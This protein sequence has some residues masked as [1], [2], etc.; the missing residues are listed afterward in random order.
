MTKPE[1][2]CWSRLVIFHGSR[3]LYAVLLLG[4]PVLVS[5]QEATDPSA[6]RGTNAS[7]VA[8]PFSRYLSPYE[9][10]YFLLGTYPAAEFQFSLKYQVFAP[11]NRW[12]R[13]STN[14]YLAYT[15]TSFW[16][17]L[18]SDPSFYDTSYKPSAFLYFPDILP[19]KKEEVIRLDLQGG[20]EHES[21]GRG[22]AAE[23]SL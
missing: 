22:G 11:T 17:L 8:T 3:L 1:Q 18:S 14:V 10:I 7:A 4:W 19:G 5:G 6:G 13:P 20:I 9:P 2:R 23:R 16:D 21:N 15:Q 12:A